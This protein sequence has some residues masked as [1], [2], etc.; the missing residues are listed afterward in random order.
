MLELRVSEPSELPLLRCAVA[1]RLARAVGL[2]QSGASGGASGG[3]AGAQTASGMEAAAEAVASAAD[4]ERELQVALRHLA[5]TQREAMSSLVNIEDALQVSG[6][7]VRACL[8]PRP[9]CC[10]LRC[11]NNRRRLSVLAARDSRLCCTRASS[12]HLVSRNCHSTMIACGSVRGRHAGGLPPKSMSVLV[13]AM[14]VAAATTAA[15]VLE[16]ELEMSMALTA[17]V[18]H[19]TR[20]RS[21]SGAWRSRTESC[22]C[23]TVCAS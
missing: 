11:V 7:L 22:G 5:A 9:A 23:T 18:C 13:M 1:D 8:P 17:M 15:T 21:R 6:L 12:P 4:T 20:S 14:A 16:M 10:V 2:G 19:T 3:D